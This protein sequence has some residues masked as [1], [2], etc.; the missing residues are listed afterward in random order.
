ML[1]M[2]T[3][4]DRQAKVGNVTIFHHSSLN[5]SMNKTGLQKEISKKARLFA[6]KVEEIVNENNVD[7][8]CAENFHIRLPPSLFSTATFNRWSEKYYTSASTSF[9]RKN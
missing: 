6:T 5:L 9:F 2:T 1:L 7:I 8:I 3:V 4:E